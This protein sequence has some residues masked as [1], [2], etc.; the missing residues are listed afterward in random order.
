MFAVNSFACI[1]LMGWCVW[2]VLHKKPDDGLLGIIIYTVTCLSAFTVVVSPE[3]GGHD[4][5]VGETTL[6]VALA[7]LAIRETILR[8]ILKKKLEF[9][10]R[11]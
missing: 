3:Y 4:P 9:I 8:F 10:S 6:H 11:P 5:E 7:L 1:V 2:S